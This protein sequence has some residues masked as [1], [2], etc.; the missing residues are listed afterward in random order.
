V[1]YFIA[2]VTHQAKSRGQISNWLGRRYLFKDPNFAFRAPNYKIQGGCGDVVK[3]AMVDIDQMLVGR[4]TKMLVQIHD[5]LLFEGHES[6]LSLIPEIVGIM[7]ST[8]P[9]RSLPLTCSV[10][11]SHTSWA[12]K[13]D[14]L[15]S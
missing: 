3:V 10:S 1:D 4:K 15:P 11:H 6:E 7:E 14:G 5:E 12:D 13:K 8:Y 9:Y 2:D